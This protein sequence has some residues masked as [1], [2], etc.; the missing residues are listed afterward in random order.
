MPAPLRPTPDEIVL[1]PE[2]A[3]LAALDALLDLTRRTLDAAWPDLGAPSHDEEVLVHRILHAAEQLRDALGDYRDV[4][5]RPL[6][7]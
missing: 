4:V 6:H 5:T 7:G 1:A 3:L 2:L